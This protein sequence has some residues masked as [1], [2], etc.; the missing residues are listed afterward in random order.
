M[1]L[2]I[3]SIPLKRAVRIVTSL[4]LAVFL[5]AAVAVGSP[6]IAMAQAQAQ[7]QNG[8]AQ[9]NINPQTRRT[10]QVNLIVRFDTLAAQAGG[11]Q[12][13]PYGCENDGGFYCWCASNTC[14]TPLKTL[15]NNHNGN[16]SPDGLTCGFP[17]L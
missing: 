4:V 17:G 7:Q 10:E 12:A 5:G 11:V 1:I 9:I 2:S 14:K 16:L 8:T 3:K 15:C 13:K 6:P